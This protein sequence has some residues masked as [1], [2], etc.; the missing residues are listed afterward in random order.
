MQTIKIQK[1][2]YF[3]GL[4]PSYIITFMFFYLLI[5]FFYPLSMQNMYIKMD[6]SSVRSMQYGLVVIVSATDNGYM[7][8]VFTENMFLNRF[9]NYANFE[10]EDTFTTAVPGKRNY[11]V[12]NLS[13]ESIQLYVGDSRSRI[14][15][16]IAFFTMLVCT[17]NI[18][19]RIS[20]A[21]TVKNKET[22]VT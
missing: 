4:V 20:Y 12:L 22:M 17:N 15:R 3:W 6:D 9:R 10:Y 16:F 21:T 11:F 18:I 19:Y 14:H 8:Y 5:L 1:R 2:L 7:G 13:R